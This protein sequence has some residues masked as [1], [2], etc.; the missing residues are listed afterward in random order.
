[1]KGGGKGGNAMRELIDKKIGIVDHFNRLTAQ[2]FG[3]NRAKP[4]GERRFKN[5]EFIGIY[6]S[7][8]DIFTQAIGSRNRRRIFKSG[9]WIDREHHSRSG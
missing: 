6:G 3:Q 4:I 5:D 1:M 2:P 7:L 9:F 8:H